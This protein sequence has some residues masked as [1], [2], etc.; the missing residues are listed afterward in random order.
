MAYT[1]TRWPW[2]IKVTRTNGEV[3]EN[4]LSSDF[5]APGFAQH[6]SRSAT[7][8]RVELSVSFV[9]GEAV[10]PQATA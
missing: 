7:V 6:A 1:D 10:S 8:E 2:H 3:T 9:N 5:D 4:D